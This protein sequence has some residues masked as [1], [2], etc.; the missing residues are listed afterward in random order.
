MSYKT[1]SIT[2]ETILGFSFLSIYLCISTQHVSDG[3]MSEP[4]VGRIFPSPFSQLF[5]AQIASDDQNQLQ[6][7]LLQVGLI[8]KQQ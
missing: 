2:R 6:S 3:L 7:S 8:R 5:P 1:I 4:T